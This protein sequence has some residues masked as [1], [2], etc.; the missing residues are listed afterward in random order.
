M[1]DT[2]RGDEQEHMQEIKRDISD[3]KSELHTLNMQIMG[4][5][6]GTRGLVRRVD[7]LEAWIESKRSLEKVAYSA[8]IT[9]AVTGVATLIITVIRFAGYLKQ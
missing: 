7:S 5:G 1:V 2:Y 8:V 6:N 9:L 4:D 3:I